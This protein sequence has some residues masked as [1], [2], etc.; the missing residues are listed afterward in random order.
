M[1]LKGG[2]LFIWDVENQ[3][4]GELLGWMPWSCRMLMWCT[5]SISHRGHLR[6]GVL[7]LFSHTAFLSIWILC[8]KFLRNYG[9][10]GKMARVLLLPC[11][12]FVQLMHLLTRRTLIFLRRAR[13]IIF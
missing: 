1:Y 8:Q 10:S 12:T 6:M 7:I 13:L 11:P 9:A 4:C 5:T 2:K 3:S